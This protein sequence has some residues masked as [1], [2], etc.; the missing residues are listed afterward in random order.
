[1]R[2]PAW[3]VSPSSTAHFA[4]PAGDA[5][6]EIHLADVHV[7]L[8]FERGRGGR[9]GEPVNQPPAAARDG[10]QDHHEEHDFFVH[11]EA[12][13]PDLALAVGA[14]DDVLAEPNRRSMFSIKT[15]S[16]CRTSSGV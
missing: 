14:G 2:S 8:G 7:A 10:E 12:R 3:T 16:I 11:R 5:E 4:H 9:R 15:A 13:F 6:G 1:M